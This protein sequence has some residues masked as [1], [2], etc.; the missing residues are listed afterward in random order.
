MSGVLEFL[1][2]ADRRGMPVL[3]VPLPVPFIAIAQEVAAAVQADMGQRLGAQLQVFGA[4][5]WI[6]V[7]NLEIAEIFSRLERLSG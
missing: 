3:E 5:R 7:E 2:A 1:A 4:L 6:T